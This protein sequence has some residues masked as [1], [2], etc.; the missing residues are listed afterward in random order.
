MGRTRRRSD[1][2]A[3][4]GQ[5]Q[6]IEGNLLLPLIMARTVDLHPGEGLLGVTVT[7]ITVRAYLD[8]AGR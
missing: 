5:I 7:R 8:R 1:D 2:W 4:H 3:P 6:E